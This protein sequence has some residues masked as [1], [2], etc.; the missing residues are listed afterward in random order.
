EDGFRPGLVGGLLARERVLAIVAG[1][2][3]TLA[4]S[5]HGRLFTWGI[6]PASSPHPPA[7]FTSTTRRQH[8]AGQAPRAVD[9]QLGIPRVRPLGR[10]VIR[11]LSFRISS[12]PSRGS[13]PTCRSGGSAGRG[14]N[15]YADE[16]ALAM[17][18]GGVLRRV[19]GGDGGC[20]RGTPWQ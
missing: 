8:A 3:F 6:P 15:T 2:Y 10:L 12:Q 20:E 7:M 16:F 14:G 17:C 9:S 4:I 11:R 1:R 18:V 13:P 5:Q 19:G